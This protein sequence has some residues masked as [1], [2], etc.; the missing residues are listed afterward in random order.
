MRCVNERE[1]VATIKQ[2]I[3]KQIS[4]I[5]GCDFSR[6]LPTSISL[7][8]EDFSQAGTRIICGKEGCSTDDT[9]F[10][11]IQAKIKPVVALVRN[12]FPSVVRFALDK[13]ILT[14]A[15]IFVLASDV[16]KEAVDISIGVSL[17][18]LTLFFDELG[19]LLHNLLTL[20]V[21]RDGRTDRITKAD[22][23][24]RLIWIISGRGHQAERV[25]RQMLKAVNTFLMSLHGENDFNSSTGGQ[26]DKCFENPRHQLH[27]EQEQ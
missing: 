22:I 21:I 23:R 12:I 19:I 13:G 17:V 1:V 7:G 16:S 15:E 8:I 25:S 20:G 14:K 27:I 5:T 10:V 6:I 3:G 9:L 26:E 4:T 18:L 11:N 24:T 2:I